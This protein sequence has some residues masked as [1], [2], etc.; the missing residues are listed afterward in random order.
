MAGVKTVRPRLLEALWNTRCWRGL[1]AR[2]W[3]IQDHGPTQRI[4]MWT[5]TPR[6]TTGPPDW[7][8]SAS[9]SDVAST[10]STS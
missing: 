4:L 9:G 7:A 10:L 3:S 2:T 8:P 1:V 5:C 6:F